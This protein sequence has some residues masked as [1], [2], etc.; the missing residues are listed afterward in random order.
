MI[1]SQQDLT[2]KIDQLAKTTGKSYG[3]TVKVALN[4]YFL[5]ERSISQGYS[6]VLVIPDKNI[7]DSLHDKLITI[8]FSKESQE[9]HNE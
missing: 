5:L 8:N 1:V 3:E 4:L 2:A 9:K 6:V 7:D